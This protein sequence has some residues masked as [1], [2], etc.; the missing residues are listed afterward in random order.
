ML[1]IF[2][3][4]QR[5][6][7]EVARPARRI[8]H[9]EFG[10]PLHEFRLQ[11]L[12]FGQRGVGLAL[13][14]TGPGGRLSARGSVVEV[15]AAALVLPAKAAAAPHVRPPIAPADLACPF[16]EGEPDTCWVR[17]LRVGLLEKAA[18]INEMRLRGSVLVFGV[19]PLFDKFL[20]CHA[21]AVCFDTRERKELSL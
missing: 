10:Q 15:S 19:T 8:E 17:F 20:W 12:G 7:Q 14:R 11:P 6:V 16:L 21:L 5:Q 18:K 13:Q 1:Q 3:R 4:Q 9:A 2:Q